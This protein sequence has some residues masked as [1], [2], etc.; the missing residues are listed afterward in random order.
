MPK[1]SDTEIYNYKDLPSLSDYLFGTDSE[2][3]K[4]N[5]NFRLNSIIQLI[6]GVNGVNNIQ[7]AFSDASDP[8]TSYFTKGMFF[9]DT[10]EGSVG[11]FSKLIFNKNALQPIDL[12]LLFEK[13]ATIDNLVL[14]IL[15]PSKP[16]TFFN[17]KIL[18]IENE[19]DYFVFDVEVLG[20]FFL[21]N[22]QSETIYSIYFD[23][24]ES[25]SDKLDRGG[26]NG[27]AKIL[28]DRI[29]VLE[30][31][32]ASGGSSDV[33]LEVGTI[34]KVGNTVSIDANSFKWKIN[35]V[36]Y[37]TTSAFSQAINTATDGYYR[38]DLLVANTSGGYNLIQGI[39]S[40]DIVSKPD[41]PANTLEVTFIPVFGSTIGNITPSPDNSVAK[42][43]SSTLIGNGQMDLVEGRTANGI[44]FFR[45]RFGQNSLDGAELEV[46]T[47]DNGGEP[48]YFRQYH[49]TYLPD[50]TYVP[51]STVVNE[52]VILDE[53]GDTRIPNDLYVNN[54]LFI[55]TNY[56]TKTEVDANLSNKVDKVAG[57]SLVSDAEITRLAGV[58]NVD[59]SGKQNTLFSGTNIK[60]INGNSI[61]GSGD[62]AIGGITAVSKIG[63]T[64]FVDTINGNNAT[65]EVEYQDKPFL[66]E[67]AAFNAI[68][69]STDLWTI[70]FIDGNVTRQVTSAFRAKN[71]I[72]KTS[73]GGIINF[74]LS[75]F[76]IGQYSRYPI[77]D[78]N[79][80][81]IDAPLAHA[82]FNVND[83][84]LGTTAE[85]FSIVTRELTFIGSMQIKSTSLIPS[86]IICDIFNTNVI[87]SDYAFF[88]ATAV[89]VKIGTWN[90][91]RFN[92]CSNDVTDAQALIS[93]LEVEILNLI[94]SENRAIFGSGTVSTFKL[95]NVTGA[96]DITLVA[97]KK[98]YAPI[99]RSE[100][101]F[102]NSIIA[103]TCNVKVQHSDNSNLYITGNIVSN[104]NNVT[105]GGP[106]G[107][108]STDYNFLN[109]TGRVNPQ[110]PNYFGITANLTIQNSAITTSGY[111][112]SFR[113]KVGNIPTSGGLLSFKIIG[114]NSII[115]DNPASTL[116]EYQIDPLIV[117]NEGNLKTNFS[118][119]GKNILE[120]TISATSKE[121]L[122]E[123]V[124]RSK[125][126]IINRVLDSSTT[127]VIDGKL[128]LAADEYIQVPST[129]LTL[130][131]YGF[132]VSGISKNVAGQS[133]FTSPVSGGSGDFI[134]RDIVYNSGA[135]R[136]F[137][138]TNVAGNNA[139]EMNDV[140]FE[141]CAS[142]GKLTG[143][144]QFTGTTNGFYGCQ[145]G[146]Q[147]SGN[148]SGFKLTNSNVLAFGASGTF[149]KK[150]TDT[151]FSNRVYL[152]LNLSFATGAKLS[153]FQ[154]SNFNGDELFQINNTLLR[155]GGV[156][157]NA[158][159]ALALPNISANNPKCRWTNCIGITLTAQKFQDLKSATKNWRISVN[160]AGVILATEI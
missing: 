131:G 54:Q 109:F 99:R 153:D 69:S 81:R 59:I 141:N 129:G 17:F 143:Y 66:T 95:G 122:K 94:A 159:T 36:E 7:F 20:D 100:I 118:S 138:L 142:L 114:H 8:E 16:D 125:L 53:N 26:Y 12:T 144:R 102:N 50:G 5:K 39:E 146:F 24:N 58:S 110:N 11:D 149:I 57:K 2:N 40:T 127:Y 76:V 75:C 41:L 97:D 21:G 45:I 132:N 23:V 150:D 3:N 148:W 87:T 112:L 74:N 90:Y 25:S 133:I 103:S 47:A 71:V 29:K 107:A 62:I 60:T 63:F 151:L 83:V 19:T 121:K 1:A 13:L 84:R 105:L 123:K 101:I 126:D 67:L 48:I 111:L 27:T 32:G 33:F 115:T 79:P 44:D 86:K 52:L 98:S 68:P 77:N 147:V 46:A 96:G 140:N 104:F 9:T 120:N 61:L 93:S 43:V 4:K 116:I 92:F 37:L 156:V 78:G 158:N 22:F 157:D 6:N 137:D 56:Y 64:V 42:K 106:Q 89:K 15:D 18:N 80:I 35:N 136:V 139:I 91:T 34:Q 88:H 152:D 72:Y 134:T 31:G 70:Q 38:I 51:F 124:I 85:P 28:D 108:G 10:N 30:D 128:I 113:D 55:P 117:L 130:V 145:D 73:F 119:F 49:F 65:G 160:D 154:E 135:G 82:I 14:K 155:I